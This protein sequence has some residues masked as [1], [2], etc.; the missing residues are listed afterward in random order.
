MGRIDPMDITIQ[1]AADK[2]GVSRSRIR[3][4]VLSGKLPAIKY[5]R[6][7]FICKRDLK[8]VV[9]RKTGRLRMSE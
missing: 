4:L 3:Q 5:G 7:W 9:N 2:L 8:L 6:D 1:Q